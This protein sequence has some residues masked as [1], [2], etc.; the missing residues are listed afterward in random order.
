MQSSTLLFRHI[1]W[2]LPI[3]HGAFMGVLAMFLH[4]SGHMA[5]ARLVG[6]KVKR[7]GFSW[8]GIYMV[9]ESGPPATNIVVALSGPLANLVLTAFWSWIP[10]FGLANL[11]CGACN[12]L[13][14]EGSDGWRAFGCLRAMWEAKHAAQQ[15][16]DLQI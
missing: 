2:F 11:C 10:V 16:H 7:V 3:L 14:I 9:R 5:A 6:L 1:Q 15:Q 13:P 8:K 12:L 4:E